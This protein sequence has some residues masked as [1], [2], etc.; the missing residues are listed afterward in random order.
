MQVF[1]ELRNV[2]EKECD[3]LKQDL[4][5]REIA[6]VLILAFKELVKAFRKVML[7]APSFYFCRLSTAFNI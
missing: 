3:L 4:K 2:T 7:L 1:Y 5:S 6:N